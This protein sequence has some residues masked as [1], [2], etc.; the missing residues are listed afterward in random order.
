MS[1]SNLVDMSDV[2]VYL[3]YAKKV[4]LR[5]HRRLLERASLIGIAIRNL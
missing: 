1:V 4:L 5:H 3:A 2:G